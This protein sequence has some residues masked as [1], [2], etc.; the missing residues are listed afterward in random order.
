M[1]QGLSFLPPFLRSSFHP[2]QNMLELYGTKRCPYT[3]DL[4]EELHWQERD[5]T[6]YDVEDDPAALERMLALTDGQRTVP[7]LVNDGEVEQI[8]W[9]GRGCFVG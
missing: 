6:E 9:K 8:G 2:F 3:A 4:R 5:F 7:V 1:M